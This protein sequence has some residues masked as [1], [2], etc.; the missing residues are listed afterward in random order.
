M[1]EVDAVMATQVAVY[2]VQNEARIIMARPMQQTEVFVPI[3][4]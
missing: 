3:L 1:V 4:A 2:V